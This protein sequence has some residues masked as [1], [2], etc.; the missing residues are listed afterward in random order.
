MYAQADFTA[1]SNY[2]FDNQTSVAPN[3]EE[4][5]SNLK[6]LVLQARDLFV[7]KFKIPKKPHPKWFDS[8][9]R[10]QLNCTRTLRKKSRLR[11]TVTNQLKLLVAETELQSAMLTAKEHYMHQISSEFGQ[12]PRKL[13]GHL[14]SLTTTKTRPDFFIVNGS[15]I[16]DPQQVANAFNHFFHS[17][18]SSPSDFALPSTSDL[19]TP[20]SQL[21]T[22]EITRTDVYTALCALDETKAYGCDEIHPKVLKK[23]LLSLLDSVHSLFVMCLS[24]RLI[25]VEWKTHK[26]TPIPK[27]GDLLEIINYRPISLLCIL[28]KVLESII[29]SKIIEFIRPK[30]SKYQFGFMKNKSCLTQDLMAFSTIHQ[31]VDNK[32]QVDIHGLPGL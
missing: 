22:V 14:R 12:N 21:S 8:V 6:H 29:Y 4:T 19:P 5:W 7:P 2:L 16:Y 31:A 9:V 26:I 18:F 24:N 1:M 30:L 25:P 27:K 3:I 17:T 23:C 15:P 28:S 20:C 11:P 13:Y 10:H 32:E